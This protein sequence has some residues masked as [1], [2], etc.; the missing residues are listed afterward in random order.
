MECRILAK[1]SWTILF[2]VHRVVLI[3]FL[4]VLFDR[5]GTVSIV[6]TSVTTGDRPP[7][8][9]DLLGPASSYSFLSVSTGFALAALKIVELVVNIPTANTATPQST[10]GTMPTAMW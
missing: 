2:I 7:A 5:R 3:A 10:I 8:T 9:G 6:L 1:S 4:T